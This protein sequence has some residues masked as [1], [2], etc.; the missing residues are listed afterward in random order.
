MLSSMAPA[1]TAWPSQATERALYSTGHRRHSDDGSGD[2]SESGTTSS[3][4]SY[5]SRRSRREKE[6]HHAA[7]P[8]DTGVSPGIVILAILLIFALG[9]AL[10]FGMQNMKSPMSAASSGS[11]GQGTVT[12]TVVSVST[13]APSGPIATSDEE[14]TGGV[15]GPPTNSGG[16][17][18]SGGASGRPQNGGGSGGGTQ[19]GTATKTGTSSSPSPT[20]GGSSDSSSSNDPMI[21]DCLAAHNDFRATHHAD[22]LVW[23]TTLQAAAQKWADHCEWE[24][25]G[26]KVGPYGENLFAVA[27]IKQTTPLDSKGGIKSWND[28]EKMYDYNKPTGYSHETGHFT[29]VVWKETKQLGCAWARCDGIFGSGVGGFLYWPGGNMVGSD[30]KYFR[31]NVLPP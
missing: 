25:S 8:A 11:S 2:D 3:D 31:D 19:S 27:P 9:V 23:N 1:R 5:D 30:N 24:H 13:A 14:T 29:Q 12:E 6:H 26:G 16:T 22:A 17:A 18:T 10:Y 28:E 7:V 21:R 20:S 4:D 15:A